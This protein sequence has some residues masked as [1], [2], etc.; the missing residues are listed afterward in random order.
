MEK[1]CF[2]CLNNH[3]ELIIFPSKKYLGKYVVLTFSQMWFVNVNFIENHCIFCNKLISKYKNEF[4]LPLKK[5]RK[6]FK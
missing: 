5:R 3:D 2:E 6:I 4:E 1:I